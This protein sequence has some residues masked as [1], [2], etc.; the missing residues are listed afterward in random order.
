MAY[1]DDIVGLCYSRG[2]NGVYS[3]YSRSQAIHRA[4]PPLVQVPV[5]CCRF[6]DSHTLTDPNL[7]VVNDVVLYSSLQSLQ[8]Y[9]GLEIPGYRMSFYTYGTA[10]Y[11]HL[12][13][14]S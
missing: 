6:I 13:G 14:G 1:A 5:A 10:N 3:Y 4:Y 12:K 2:G 11:G 9:G 7:C 8:R